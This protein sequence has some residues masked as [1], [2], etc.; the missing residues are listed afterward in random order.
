MSS[1]MEDTNLLCIS[2]HFNVPAKLMLM[3]YK[4]YISWH[5][6]FKYAFEALFESAYDTS[7]NNI[8]LCMNS[9]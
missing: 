7:D 8:I 1:F 5:F 4:F 3:S 2:S 9:T 6:S